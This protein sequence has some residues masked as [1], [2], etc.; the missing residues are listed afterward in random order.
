[1]STSQRK[2]GQP[3]VVYG[4]H[5]I[6]DNRGNDVKVANMADPIPIKA[7]LVPQRSARAEVPGQVQIDI[8]RIGVDADLPGVDLW[9]RV[10]WRGSYWDIVSPPAYHHGTRHTRHQTI[11]LRKRP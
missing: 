11:D 10:Y 2:R 1:V 7:W 3:A 9:S 4:T 5:T 6:T 8:M